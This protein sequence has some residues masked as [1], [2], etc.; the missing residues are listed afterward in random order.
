MQLQLVAVRDNEDKE[1]GKKEEE[2]GNMMLLL[3]SSSHTLLVW[4]MEEGRNHTITRA[5][6]FP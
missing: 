3:S 5:R 2:D 4:R 6:P 1:E